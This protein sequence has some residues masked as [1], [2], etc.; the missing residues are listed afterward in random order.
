VRKNSPTEPFIMLP[1]SLIDSLAWRTAG[2]NA[3]KLLWFLMLEHMAKGGKANGNLLAPRKQLTTF[4]I[5]A[6]HI[7]PAITEANDLGLIDVVRGRGR[8]PNR[9]ALTW[10]PLQGGGEPS[11]RWRQYPAQCP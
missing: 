8:A 9:Y 7:S 6:R 10:L 3:H 1:R 2:I 11:N 5:G 4:G